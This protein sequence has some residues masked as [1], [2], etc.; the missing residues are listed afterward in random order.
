MSWG[1]LIYITYVNI[2]LD[3]SMIKI[4]ILDQNKQIWLI[5]KNKKSKIH[6]L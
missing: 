1:Y 6:N 3:I 4:V 2:V 5:L